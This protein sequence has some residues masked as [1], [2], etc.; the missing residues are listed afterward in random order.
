[1][2]R[3]ILQPSDDDGEEDEW[4][5]NDALEMAREELAQEE[6][7]ALAGALHRY[8]CAAVLRAIPR[9][10]AFNRRVRELLREHAEQTGETVVT[11]AVMRSITDRATRET[12]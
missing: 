2:V 12:Q 8:P 1:M 11:E 6:E 7:H 10:E 4:A 3:R 5:S 9:L